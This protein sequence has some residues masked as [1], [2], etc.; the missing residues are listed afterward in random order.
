LNY[1]ESLDGISWTQLPGN[2]VINNISHGQTVKFGAVYYYYGVP[3]ATPNQ[4]DLYTSN[5]GITWVLDTAAVLPPGAGG[6][7]DDF[8]MGNNF[9]WQ[10]GVNDWRMIYEAHASAADPW[11]LGYATSAN[12]RIWVKNGGNPIINPVGSIGGP[13][14][15]RSIAGVYWMWTHGSPTGFLPTDI[16]RYWSNDG[17]AWNFDRR[18]FFRYTQDEGKGLSLSQVADVSL[19]EIGGRTYMWYSASQDGTAP[20]TGI[21][22]LATTPFTLEQIITMVEDT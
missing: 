13:E 8:A 9:V 4:I 17:I 19:G 5:D 7:W 18:T 3:F 14:I 10:G 11:A 21:I 16:S 20:G 1:A 15:Y 22:K 6:S 12:G 2:P